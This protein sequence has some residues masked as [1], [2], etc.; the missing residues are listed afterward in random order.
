MWNVDRWRMPKAHMAFGQVIK[1]AGLNKFYRPKP[2]P[3]VKWCDMPASK[4]PTFTYKCFYIKLDLWLTL[5]V[6]YWLSHFVILIT[7]K[8]QRM[9]M[10][11]NK[12]I[13]NKNCTWTSTTIWRSQWEVNVFLWV[14][15]YYVGGNV[16][17]LFSHS[18][19]K[20]H[21]SY[22]YAYL[23]QSEILMQN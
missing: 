11:K 10:D 6:M 2:T 17:H 4:T 20:D 18:A 14:Q 3:L 15:S 1:V 7:C 8:I 19:K 21:L 13:L 22:Y 12:I 5:L 9:Y 16:Y 23:Y